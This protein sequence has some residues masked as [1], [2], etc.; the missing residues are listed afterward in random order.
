MAT[1]KERA[2]LMKVMIVGMTG[3]GLGGRQ[4]L[5]KIMA[6]PVDAREGA[7]QMV[8]SA[9]YERVRDRILEADVANADGNEIPMA[10]IESGFENM[11]HSFHECFL[12]LGM[13][14]DDWDRTKVCPPDATLEEF[15]S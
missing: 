12:A 6:Q 14:A 11:H 8:D 7:L 9:A 5:S 2:D 15:L 4:Y 10:L 3:D 13:G 1:D